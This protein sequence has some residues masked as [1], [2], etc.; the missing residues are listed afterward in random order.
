M[1][2]EEQRV[3]YSRQLAIPDIGVEGQILLGKSRVMV[4][5]LGGLGSISSYYLAAAGAGSLRI[6]DNDTVALDN[7]NRQLLHSTPDLRRPK[8]DSA[9]EKL[10][11]LNPECRIEP[12]RAL[13]GQDNGFDLAEG[14]DLIID[15]TDNLAT[16]HVLNRISL[17]RRIPLVYGGIS[18]WNGTASTFVPGETCCFACLVRSE[19]LGTPKTVIPAF[20]PAAG[21]I[22][23]I[24]ST[25]AVRILLGMRPS[26]ANRLLKFQGNGLRFR[27]V[28]VGK[29]P[30]CT[31]CGPSG[32]E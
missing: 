2:T 8:A 9:A 6:V 20:G 31:R 30:D 29:D 24:Q 16:R 12:I 13:I 15:A 22:G 14:C 23:S 10:R 5:G 4:V 11:R 26:L 3:R 19:D 28:H 27:V 21:V 17:A 25:E 32:G 1:L 7:L 18:G